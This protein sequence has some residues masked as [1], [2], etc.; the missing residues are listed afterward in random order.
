[1]RTITIKFPADPGSSPFH[2][3]QQVQD[4]LSDA[5]SCGDLELETH[6]YLTVQV[7]MP[8]YTEGYYDLEQ[9]YDMFDVDL[10]ADEATI[11]VIDIWNQQFNQP[12]Q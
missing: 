1:M 11:R 2:V 5:I 10:T 9:T 8:R 4:F 12:L 7:G 6:Q 3:Q